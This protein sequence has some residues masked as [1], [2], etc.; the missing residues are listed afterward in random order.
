[1]TGSVVPPC[2]FTAYISYKLLI[3]KKEKEK[4]AL[5]SEGNISKA[6]PLANDQYR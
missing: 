4:E 1:M 5:K 2:R 3:K 6:Y